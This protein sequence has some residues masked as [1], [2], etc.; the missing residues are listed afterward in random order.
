[1]RTADVKLGT[2]E[3][4]IEAVGAIA[5]D[6][7]SV[8]VVQARV[9]G[10]I[11]RLFVRAPL[12]PVSKGQPLARSW[13]PTGSPRRR[14]TCAQAQPA[15]E[16]GIAGKRRASAW[17]CLGM[18]AETIAAIEAD[19]KARPPRDTLP[20]RLRRHRRARR[21]RGHVGHAGRDAV[22]HQR[23][24][25]SLG[26]TRGSGNQA[27]WFKPGNKV[28]AIVPPIP[29]KNSPGAFPRCFPR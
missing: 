10:Y 29:A 6:E 1:V 18:P 25:H 8:A 27:S 24:R 2:L 11:E 16:R 4:R 17:G 14:N 15:G 12:D 26:E 22:S 9:N 23:A 13:H 5:F 28:E 19:G 3:K 20:R 7:R 21:A